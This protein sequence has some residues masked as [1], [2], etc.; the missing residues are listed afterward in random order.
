MSE[1]AYGSDT[2]PSSQYC[3]LE[4]KAGLRY[5][6]NVKP[7]NFSR[8]PALPLVSQNTWEMVICIP[9]AEKAERIVLVITYM[10][11]LCAL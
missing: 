5:K 4:I 7:T 3:G 2:N 9:L 10:T 11:F 1:E 6:E 8:A